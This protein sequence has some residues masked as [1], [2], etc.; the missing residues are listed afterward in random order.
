MA[1]DEWE[2]L[3]AQAASGQSAHMQLNH[4]DGGGAR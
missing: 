3:K 1:W 2:Q 4:V